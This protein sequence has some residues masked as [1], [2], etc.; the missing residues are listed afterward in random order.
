MIKDKD[1]DKVKYI[2]ITTNIIN[3]KQYIGQHNGLLNDSYIGSGVALLTA[4][5][6]YG[7]ANFKKEILQICL[8]QEELDN[9]EKYWIKKYNAISSKKFYNIA[10][11]GLG[12]NPIA[13]LSEERE[14]ERRR[15]ISESLKGEKIL[16]IKRDFMV[17]TTLCGENITLKKQEIK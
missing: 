9:A 12:G 2:Y 10:E 13:G 16:F 15:K 8:T 11:G 1:K 5:K 17:K 6:K 7:K 4:I 14:A 3:G